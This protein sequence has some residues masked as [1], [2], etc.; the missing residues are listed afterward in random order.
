M[1]GNVR[2]E[3]SSASPDEL[4]FPG[5][6][7]NGQRG[8]Y[9]GV[10]FDR[11][12]SF[13]EGNESRMFSPG[14]STSRGGST[15]AADVPPLSLWLTLDPITMGDQKYTRSGELRK[16]L[17]IS[18]G[19]AAEDN[20][21]GAAHMKPPPVATEELKRFKSSISET[22]MRART[23][24]KKLDECL[25]K[26]NKYFETI[27]S[28]KQQRNEMLTNERSGSNLLKM[29][30][31]MQ[32]NPS[33]VVSQ[34][35]EDRT[36]NVVMNKRVRSS[37]AELRAEGRSN[38]PARQ[39][40]VMGKDKD[41]PK[42]N[43]ESS[44][45]VEE[46]IRRLPT[47]GEGW[48][49]KMKRKRSIGTVFTRPMD[50]DGELKR[51]MHHKLNNE[52]GLQSSDTQGFR[53]GLSNG[54]NGINKF[55]GT[56]L[57]ANSSV[58]G[59]SRND[60][61]KLSLSRDFVAGSTKERILAKGNNKL[62]IRED[63]HLV[64]NI[65]VTKGKASRGP[66]SGPVVAAN[67]SPN[68]PR[69]SGALDGW[70]Q[71]PSA[72]KVHSVGGANNRKRPLP[73]GSSSPPMAQWGGQRPQKI[74][75]TRRTNLVSPVSNLDELQ[76]S[77]EGCLPDLGSK[78][79]SVGTTE[80]ILA[81]GMVNGAQQ[82]KIKHE[83]VSSSA[84]LSESEES[85]A[86]ENRESR[87]KDKAM[88]SNEVEERTMNAVQ[89]IGSSVLLTKENKMPEEES[90]D[91]VRRQGRSGRGSSNSRT[92]FSP[93]MEKLENPTSTKPLKITRHGSDKSG[94]K[95][96][97]PP[98]KKL[99]DRK[100][101]RLGLTP[102]GSPDLCGESDDD[103][104]ELLAAANFSCN[105]SYLKCSSSFWKQME[106]I[107]VPISLEDSSHLKQELRST[108]DHHNSLTQ[109][110]SL[111]E[112]DVLSQTSLSGETARSL[113]DQNYSKE[114]ARTVDFVDQVEE[115]VSFSERSNAGGKQIS[116]LYQRVLSAL[117]VE[118]KTA[119]FEENGRWSNAFFQH[120]REDLPG[121]T[122]LPTKVE[123]GK[124]LW[125]EAAHESMLS[126]QAQ[127]HSIGDNF[128]CNG[129]TTF[130]SAASYH[131]QLQNDDLLPDGC[132]FS[133]SD[134]G[135]LSEVSK[136]GSGG[137]LSIHIISSGISSPDCQYGQMSLEDKLILELLNIGI[138]VE[139]VPD[140]ADGEDEIID[141]DIVELQ[142]R[143]NQQADKKKKYFNKIINAVEEVKKNEGRN[144]EQLAMDR[145]V[146]IAY[147]KRLATRAS[148]ASKSGITKVSKQVALAFIKRTLARCQKFEETGK[149]CFT[150]P[151][152]R[153]VIFSAP[154][155]GI[156]SESVKGFGSVVAASM[157][158]ENNNSHMEP[159]GPDPLASRVERLHNDKIGGA[160]FDGFGTL[161]DP[162]H[163]EFAK[164]R[165]ILNRWKKKDV[166]LNDV[167]G[168][169][170]L[171]AASALDNTVLGGAKGKRS[172]RE[173]DKDI[174]VSSGKA[175]RASIGNLKGERKTKSKPKQKTAQLSTS[176]NGFSNKLT[177]T[178]RPT[179]NKKRVGL[180]SHDNVPQ[181][182]FQEMKE[183]LDLQLPEF[184]S[185]EELGVANQDLD[186]WLNIEEDGLQ[187]HDLMGLQIPMDDLSDIL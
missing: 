112:E 97:R 182:S 175:G 36:K 107:F 152:Y 6:Y 74:S 126:P 167:S 170:S 147:K 69:S 11:S 81:K 117:I 79:T 53:S 174:K 129:F 3:L 122:C 186:T 155:R 110:D 142:K 151:A 31:L 91:G 156:D 9:P 70:E 132:G 106:P 65:P 60:V 113:Q 90:G 95:S 72:N 131:P 57:A 82:L 8:N 39:P 146:E 111:H 133:N 52:P 148:C 49:K 77:S 180:M 98:L 178:T 33:D 176:G 76:V 145:L 173:R 166:L 143:L 141:Q 20:S 94:S 30:I 46:K 102:T 37:M 61:E 161:T 123:A 184:G 85:A 66:R 165:P 24:A 43:G 75:R 26:L 124:G 181:D 92:S 144:L 149:S 62:N 56:S 116:P 41:M 42:D 103:R 162:S 87:L 5:S 29:G 40:L 139:S 27:G 108:E 4:S 55:D 35:L 54:T 128:P 168:S 88:G 47:G 130:S 100:L 38:M 105:A 187:D 136:N 58:R 160:P 159:G 157:Q 150:E 115:I 119:E 21:F 59:M 10:S 22:F 177:E 71:S 104:E 63:N 183:Q 18:F 25:Q 125:V 34:R 164:T 127:K 32:R 64:S 14:T 96:G 23:R 101:T 185:I 158:P 73:S 153:D 44:D 50:S 163:Q 154:P 17:G 15:S 28:K 169:A 140:L 121:G 171:R 99:S 109:G 138:C 93:M 89:N 19:S 7:P 135:M 51:A 84:R 83:N 1:V 2:V 134:R 45:L 80:L 120:H 13:R 172:E 114:S 68:F 78:V 86:G 137:P 67:S 118:D 16:V 179:G 12:G 48:D